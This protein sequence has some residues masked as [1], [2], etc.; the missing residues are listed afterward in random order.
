MNK[1]TFFL[2]GGI[3]TVAVAIPFIAVTSCSSTNN[4]KYIGIL[5]K[6]TI[7][8]SIIEKEISANPIS[9]QTLNKVFDGITNE[10]FDQV[11]SAWDQAAKTIT[12]TAK[13][14]YKFGT[15]KDPQDTV[16]SQEINLATALDI[17]VNP[18]M[19][20]SI[21]IL[22]E[23]E[24]PGNLSKETLDKAFTGITLG[25]MAHFDSAAE[26]TENNNCR[27]ILTAKPGYGF[28]SE[29]GNEMISSVF[30]VRKSNDLEMGR[31]LKIANNDTYKN[32]VKEIIFGK[33]QPITKEALNNFLEFTP[34]ERQLIDDFK[35][36]IKGKVSLTKEELKQFY[37]NAWSGSSVMS[38]Y[39]LD[40]DNSLLFDELVSKKINDV[41]NSNPKF[42]GIFKHHSS[43]FSILIKNPNNSEETLGRVAVYI[44]NHNIIFDQ[45]TK[46][47]M[48]IPL[49][50]KEAPKKL[51]KKEALIHNQKETIKM[52]S[53]FL[54]TYSYLPTNKFDLATMVLGIM[55]RS[56]EYVFVDE[57]REDN[58]TMFP[59]IDG[60]FY[61]YFSDGIVQFKDPA[62]PIVEFAFSGKNYH[63]LSFSKVDQLTSLREKIGNINVNI[64][65][66]TLNDDGT[67]KVLSTVEKNE[68]EKLNQEILVIMKEIKKFT[69]DFNNIISNVGIN[70]IT[71]GPI[72]IGIINHYTIAASSAGT[73]LPAGTV[74]TNTST[75]KEVFEAIK[76]NITIDGKTPITSPGDVVWTAAVDPTGKIT[77]KYTS[78]ESV[79]IG[80][81]LSSPEITFTI[82]K[83]ST[84]P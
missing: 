39:Y 40:I 41:I 50:W 15:E 72:V 52:Q 75:S 59:T 35:V 53:I 19:N 71:D 10:T 28:D 14:G 56:G 58:F 81:P 36:F 57:V 32:Q 51:T 68:I 29:T 45:A 70:S 67:D 11:N 64:S 43:F 23:V 3:S 8:L 77:V 9:K 16:V 84:T 17:T 38:D 78:K 80:P 18:K 1:K 47:M 21:F 44:S 66:I 83:T 25:N 82:A 61:S 65:Q 49:N 55:P 73:V 26:L 2:I 12:L 27:I 42:K 30:S 4:T 34:E 79:F 7:T 62:N 31:T 5:P 20:E 46:D 54:K 37:M 60:T 24:W 48:L 74:L 33:D 69:T 13:E 63:V 22:G 6:S 76:N